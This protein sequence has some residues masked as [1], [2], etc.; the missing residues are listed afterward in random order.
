[1]LVEKMLETANTCKGQV[2]LIVKF[3]LKKFSEGFSYQKV[4]IFEFGEY[5]DADTKTVLKIQNL[6]EVE[7]SVLD[8]IQVHNLAEERSVGL[9]NYE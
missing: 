4:A 3:L 5:K 9:I 7:M 2:S 8:T 1:M 6:N